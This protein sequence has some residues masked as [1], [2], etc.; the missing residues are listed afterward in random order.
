M[1]DVLAAGGCDVQDD[2]GRRIK[3]EG[4]Q[5]VD[6]AADTLAVYDGVY[7]MFTLSLVAAFGAARGRCL[8]TA[9][10]SQDYPDGRPINRGA[11]NRQ[12]RRLVKRPG[13][14]TGRADGF[15]LH[16]LRRFFEC[17]T[18]NAG[19]PQRV[20]DD[21][22]GHASDKSMASIYYRLR[23]EESQVYMRR[24]PFEDGPPANDAGKEGLS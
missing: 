7:A 21:W 13:M 10:P 11:S 9:S 24:V 3:G 20:V 8:F 1:P 18:V 15:T 4:P 19:N 22:L 12:F 6:T 17:H 2:E 14:P 5:V 23:D 16:S